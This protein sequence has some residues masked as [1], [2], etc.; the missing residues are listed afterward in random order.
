MKTRWIRGA[1][2]AATL[3]LFATMLLS[4]NG[5]LAA[6]NLKTPAAQL[7]V[8]LGRLLAEHA[9]LT[10]EQMRSAIRQGP[11]LSA[12]AVA[13][14]GNTADLQ[15]AIAGIYGAGAGQRFGELWRSHIA[16]IVD[17]SVALNTSD[18]AGQDRAVGQLQQFRADFAKFL[19]S[20]NPNLPEAALSQLLEDHLNQL[21][22]MAAFARK[23]YEAAY[24]TARHLYAHMFTIGDAL[25]GGIAAQF[26]HKFAG[27]NVAKS[28]ALDLRVTLD[29]LLGEHAFLAAEAMRAGITRADDFDAA[30]VALEGNS[31]DL[32]KAI[33][34]IYGAAGG[35]A[36]GQLWRSHIKHYVEYIDAV[37]EQDDAA[38][39]AALDGLTQYRATFSAFLAKANPN[40]KASTLQS[41]LG[42]HGRHLIA[43]V[44]QYAAGDYTASYRS[45]RESYAHMFVISDALTAA[46]ATQFPQ[47]FP[48]LPATSTLDDAAYLMPPNKEMSAWWLVPIV[49]LLAGL[50]GSRRRYRP[51]RIGG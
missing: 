22:G 45:A 27:A 26:P 23:D 11:D 17:Y 39:Q 42:M 21:E 51:G 43:E 33:G 15:V 41:M 1:S 32:Q 19:A 47:K 2:R 35:R 3:A 7:R 31:A 24:M 36:F 29:R 14:E 9:F 25:A 5:A 50:V 6:P 18:T 44:D 30:A 28:P 8:T 4:S 48:A 16:T 20:A 49:L 37:V 13:A 38:K 40:L 46:I 34:S 12:A 10:V